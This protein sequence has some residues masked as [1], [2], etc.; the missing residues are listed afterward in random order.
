MEVEPILRK[1]RVGDSNPSIGFHIYRI[2]DRE[3]GLFLYTPTFPGIY[4][5]NK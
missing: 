2:G 4:L 5:T 1:E 3:S